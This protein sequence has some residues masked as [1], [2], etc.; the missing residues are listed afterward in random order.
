MSS[1]LLKHSVWYENYK[2]PL[3]Y[4]HVNVNEMWMGGKQT[5]KKLETT[6]KS[7]KEMQKVFCFSR[8][9]IN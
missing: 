1:C 3:M 9:V 2:I 6:Q 5:V 4:G 8:S 7:R